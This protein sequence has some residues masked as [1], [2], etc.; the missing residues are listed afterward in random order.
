M[1]INAYLVFDGNCREAVEF[2]ADVFGL[3]KPEIMLFG[4]SPS[5]PSFPMSEEMKNLVMH[6]RLNIT[7]STLM[8]SDNMPGTPYTLGNHISLAFVSDDVDEIKSAYNKMKVGGEVTMELEETFFS[9]CYG[10]V[11][12]KFGIEWQFSYD[13]EGMAN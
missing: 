6:S 3:E 4:D 9:K 13:N 11:K 12:D 5:D 2:Y 8:F 10:Q 1:A 7:G